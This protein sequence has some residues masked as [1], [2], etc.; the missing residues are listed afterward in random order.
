[1]NNDKTVLIIDGLNEFL[2]NWIV[3]PLQSATTGDVVGGVF[4]F[5]R[6]L[7]YLT[8]SIKPS[9]I[10]IAWEGK[11]SSKKRKKIL[12]E[13]KAGRAPA[14]PNRFYEETSDDAENNKRLQLSMLFKYLDLLPIKSVFV[15]GLEGDD[16]IAYLANSYYK[17]YKRVILSNDK[18]FFQLLDNRT[19]I[20]RTIKREYVTRKYVLSKFNILPENFALANS[21]KGDVSDNIKGVKGMGYKNIVK[22]FPLLGEEELT[23]NDLEKYAQDYE[24][25]SIVLER[26]L[27]NIDAIKTNYR[28]IRLDNSLI[29]LS[30]IKK[31]EYSL[32]KELRYDKMELLRQFAQ[33]GITKLHYNWSNVFAYLMKNGG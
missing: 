1:M 8:Y 32:N 20:Y 12:P 27:D 22:F 11:G 3:N 29:S 7:S 6:S 5:L 33:D 4:G 15:D 26:F 21:L 16:I 14:K 28:V 10:I 23:I 30:Q 18:D 31:I 24:K 17:D 13:Y 2:R 25:K 19:I 9:E